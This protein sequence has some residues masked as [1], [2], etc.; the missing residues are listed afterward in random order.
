MNE[1]YELQV[2][3]MRGAGLAMGMASTKTI[4]REQFDQLY[5]AIS[6]A[7]KYHR[8]NYP[9]HPNQ[10]VIFTA[11]GNGRWTSGDL[12]CVMYNINKKEIK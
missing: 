12:S 8:E 1:F 10:E 5:K 2:E 4:K 11:V 3:D 7:N 9:N 6:E